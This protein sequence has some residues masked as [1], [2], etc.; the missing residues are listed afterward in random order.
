MIQRATYDALV[1]GARCAGAATAML[2]A[3]RGLR[4]LLIDRGDYGTDT[5]STHAL[6]RGG[7]LQLHRWG[8]L[9]RIEEAGTPAIRRAVFH[10]G[11]EVVEFSIGSSHGVEALY[12]PRR[13]VLDR[14]LVNAAWDA[15]AEIRYGHVL[16]G[17]IRSAD[18][19]VRGAAIRDR[20]GS[21][22]DVEANLVVGADGVGSAVARLVC[23]PVRQQG[24]HASA[25]VY[26]HW[27]GIRA[28]GYHWY[29]RKGMSAGVIP[30]NT[31]CGES[32]A[33]T[34]S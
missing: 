16:A 9:P 15:G 22:V 30:T 12:A 7:V 21:L 5:L 6:I 29:Y 8:V 4:V 11:D 17:L 2:M 18:G 32:L 24:R 28:S 34:A 13:T 19:R 33:T 23:A 20:A 25:V 14:V 31:T 27:S 10:Y 3:R 1:V 26:G